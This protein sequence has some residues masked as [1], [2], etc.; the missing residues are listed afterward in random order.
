MVR[1]RKVFLH[2]FVTFCE[3]VPI[4]RFQVS[5]QYFFPGTALVR[6]MVRPRSSMSAGLGTVV[7]P[8]YP[9]PE[10]NKVRVRFPFQRWQRLEMLSSSCY[11]LF[12]SPPATKIDWSR[13]PR[14]VPSSRAGSVPA[15]HYFS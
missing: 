2:D 13:R 12:P 5:F 11:L 10:E 7:R 6:H 15:L 4:S 9:Q 8:I 1:G 3:R 14:L